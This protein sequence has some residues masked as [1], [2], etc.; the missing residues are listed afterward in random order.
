M[1]RRFIRPLWLDA[2]TIGVSVLLAVIFGGISL[3]L[4]WAQRNRGRLAGLTCVQMYAHAA[5]AADTARIDERVVG[6]SRAVE[7]Y[8]CGDLRRTGELTPGRRAPTS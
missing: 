2:R 6:S 3:S 8:S 1:T 5:T 7:R 4:S